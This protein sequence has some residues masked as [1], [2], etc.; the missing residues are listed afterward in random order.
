[1]YDGDSAGQ[2]AIL[3]LTELCWGVSLDLKV[4]SL[5]PKED[6]ASLLTKGEKLDDLIRQA[7]DI[8]TFFI[9]SV[10]S[11][12]MAK[13]LSDK[14]E[15]SRRIVEVISKLADPFKED[16]LLQQA[17]LSM[18]VPFDSI[19]SLLTS[20]KRAARYGAK[21][22]GAVNEEA[23]S[24]DQDSQ[25][26]QLVEP[27]ALKEEKVIEQKLFSAIINNIHYD[28]LIVAYEKEVAHYFSPETKKLLDHYIACRNEVGPE[29]AFNKFLTSL[30]DTS[31]IRIMRW[32]V[33]YE[34]GLT[35]ELFEQFV[36]HFRKEYW[37]KAVFII[38][39]DIVKA[40]QEN[41]T[42]KVKALLEEFARV[43]QDMQSKGLV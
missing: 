32:S 27:E 22:Y 20:F 33:K 19:K 42:E 7:P 23:V 6:P 29:E 8:F 14:L 11:N 24:A 37:K 39:A 35:P 41:D 38:K 15:I 12:F 26:D 30:D 31:K 3:R 40:R 9:S 2:N 25:N 21:S 1:M 4:V 5:P 43:K 18:Q 10:G 17:S 13:P 16:I 28:P 34:D 36:G